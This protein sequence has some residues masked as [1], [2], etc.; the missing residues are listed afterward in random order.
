MRNTL[1][2][3]LLS[4]AA[5]ALSMSVASAASMAQA[6][7]DKRVA[8]LEREI[9]LLKSQMKS[10]MMAKPADKNIQS[11]NS[12]V[13]VSIYGQVNRAIRFASTGDE[14]EITSVDND[15]S[16]SRIGIRAVGK[17]NANTTIGAWHELEWQENRRSGTGETSSNGVANSRVRARHVDLWLDNKDMGKISMGHGSIAG[18]ASGLLELTGVSHVF[19]FA[20]ANGTDGVGADA[21]VKVHSG[22]GADG[23]ESTM[24]VRGKARGFRP[25]NFFGARENRLR[26]DTP[27]LMGA[28]LS[29]SYNESN[30]WSV[31]LRYA[32][33]PGGAKD[34]TV[35]FG[36]GYRKNDLDKGAAVESA[37]AVSGGIKHS[38][39][40]NLS[41]SYDADGDER[42]NGS[43]MSQWGVSG[44][45]S[46]K[47]N[48]LGGTSLGIGYNSSKDGLE[49]SAQQYWVA[50]N[51]RIDAAAADV[52]AGV[53]YDTGSV[54]HTVSTAEGLTAD[55]PADGSAVP[56]VPALAAASSPCYSADPDN[57]G[58]SIK[59]ATGT[60]CEV[61]RKGVFVFIA[62]MRLKF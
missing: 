49:G 11:G 5:L 21:S 13:K 55:R 43:K 42:S 44:G 45:W 41:G 34:F 23:V 60:T 31:G 3:A 14:T 61:D 56:E 8:D 33:S 16:S 36:A 58:Q 54:T 38:S 1:R 27:S 39:G 19:G 35:L 37:F 62:G 53:S 32:G 24:D 47:V 6:G 18:D 50:I 9:T 20:G 51:Q 17:V 29:A 2:T 59:A 57:A 22:G 12:R 4:G 15:G 40:F 52:Y 46:G 30:G 26:L 10:A 25:F 28:R 7:M 48:D